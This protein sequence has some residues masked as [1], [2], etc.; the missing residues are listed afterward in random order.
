MKATSELSR[1]D[2]LNAGAT[3]GGGFIV[4]LTVPEIGGRWHSAAAAA[5]AAGAPAAGK[6]IGQLNAWLKIARDNS[7]TIIVDRSEMGQGVYTA[8]PMLLAEEL[9]IDMRLIRIEAAPVGDAYINPGNGGQVT[10]TS[11][12]VQDAWEKLRMAGATARTMLVSAAAKRWQIDPAQCRVSNG[13]VVNA[14]GKVLTY[15]ELADAAAKEPV[16]KELK[17]K[18]KSEFQLVG[19]SQPRLDTPGKV[20]GSAGFGL[21]IK[22]PGM[23]HAVLA[24]SPVLGGKVKNVDSGAAE[25]MPGVH[26]VM[27]TSSGVVVVADHFWQA[28]QARG[29]LLITWDSGANVHLD[30]AGIHA[31]L[32][33][34]A[35]AGV[36]LSARND[37][38]VDSALKSAKQSLSA[39][40]YLPLLAHATMEPMNCTADVK[41][42]G[43]DLYVG[44]QVQQVAQAAAATAAGLEPAQ[45]RV[46]TTLI[47]GG[48]GRRLDIDFVPA[49]VEASKALGVPVKVIWTREDDMTHDTYRPPAYEEVS[50]GVDA[51]GKVV[52]WKLHITSPSITARM[53]PPVKG[54]D[55][56]VIEAAVNNLYDVRNLSVSYSR[57]EIG[58]DVGYMRSVSHAPNCFVIESFMDELAA[59]AGKNPYDFRLAQLTNKPRQRRVLQ[60]AA[61]RA[62][63]GKAP[64]GRYQGIALMEGYTTHL[65]QVAEISIEHGQLKVHKITCVVDCGQMVNPRIVESQIES[66]IIFGLTAALWGEVTLEGGRVQQTNFHNYR[67][68]RNNE[69]PELDVHLVDGDAAPG[70]IGEAAVPLVAPAI[71]NAIFTATGTRLRE[72]PI[73]KQ[74]LQKA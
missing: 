39:A 54:V 59:A 50:G 74:K 4:A 7:I 17:L 24:Q 45:V 19:K 21:D 70:G 62:G 1:R 29:A 57:Q 71:C 66:G 40:Y 65:A 3:V 15:G 61:E 47:G 72:L 28:L 18:P 11:N 16:P 51:A 26:R 38:N 69:V 41:P 12:S 55:D 20:D 49:A 58:I 67:L 30:N 8:L 64:A 10:G 43:C 33:K 5:T 46:F 23:L 13:T 34:T 44:T 9:G 2:F 48:F 35:A 63:W 31:L 14:Q 6:S 37:G 42:N 60:L 73:G 56:S 32:K 68:L 53:F 22:L 52:A 36:G 27:V 25:K